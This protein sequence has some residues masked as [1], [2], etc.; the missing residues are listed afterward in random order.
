[1]DMKATTKLRKNSGSII[2]TIPKPIVS[3]LNLNTGDEIE[4]ELKIIQNKAI[5]TINPLKEE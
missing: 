3:L 2:T 1:M 4:W 5:I